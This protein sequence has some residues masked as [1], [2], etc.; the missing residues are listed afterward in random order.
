MPPQR[1][2][3]KSA[4]G[5]GQFIGANEGESSLPDYNDWYTSI[6]LQIA[7]RQHVRLHGASSAYS[8]TQ[9]ELFSFPASRHND[10]VD[11]VRSQPD[12][13]SSK[14]VIALAVGKVS[15]SFHAIIAN[16]MPI[17]LCLRVPVHKRVFKT[18]VGLKLFRRRANGVAGGGG[19]P[20]AGG[21]DD[22]FPAR[23]ARTVLPRGCGWTV[24]IW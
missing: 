11:A 18:P 15:S 12:D 1:F 10:Q 22:G 2:R 6:L 20:F 24:T 9:A 7:S 5:A 3:P 19:R 8:A 17:G 23:S 21:P 14:V 13:Q 16:T 4:D